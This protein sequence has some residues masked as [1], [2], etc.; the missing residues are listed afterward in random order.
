MVALF[1]VLC[2]YLLSRDKIKSVNCASFSVL[3]L[4]LTMSLGNPSE[5]TPEVRKSHDHSC[6]V[7]VLMGDS[8]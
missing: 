1:S 8:N 4:S 5:S 3:A 2:T 7:K 6:L